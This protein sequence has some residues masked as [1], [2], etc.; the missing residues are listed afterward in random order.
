M[1]TN[2]MN[3]YYHELGK[4][5]AIAEM[6][7]VIRFGDIENLNNTL[8]KIAKQLP[9]NPHAKWFIEKTKTVV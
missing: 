6:F 1:N 9:D 2:N 3:Q 4:R 8:I 7:T 5:D